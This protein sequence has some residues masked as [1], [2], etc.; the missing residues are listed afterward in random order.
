M[1]VPSGVSPSVA[2]YLPCSAVFIYVR[3][4]RTGQKRTEFSCP[5]IFCG[6]RSHDRQALLFL[7]L[8]PS[9]V[10]CITVW[11]VDV[12]VRFITATR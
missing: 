8:S 1:Q 2:G 12:S 4:Y 11:L 5:R 7:P 6:C 3:A 9:R 10:Q